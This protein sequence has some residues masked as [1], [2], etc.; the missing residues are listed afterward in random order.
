[1]SLNPFYIAYI[2]L[3]SYGK[4]YIVITYALDTFL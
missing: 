1:M 4:F 2:Y 3:W